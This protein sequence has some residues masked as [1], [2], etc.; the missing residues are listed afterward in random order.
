MLDENG[1]AGIDIEVTG[2]MIDA[3]DSALADQR[4]GSNPRAV[5]TEVFLAMVVAHF[6]SRGIKIDRIFNDPLH[7]DEP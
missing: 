2:D 5:V 7:I 1:Q 4:Y 6:E 3:G